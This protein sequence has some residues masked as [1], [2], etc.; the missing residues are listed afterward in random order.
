MA[1]MS[2]ERTPAEA[3]PAAITVVDFGPV[4]VHA[5]LS[6]AEALDIVTRRAKSGE[7]GFVLDA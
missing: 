1:T 6:L 3:P 4:P 5:A 7:G 2:K